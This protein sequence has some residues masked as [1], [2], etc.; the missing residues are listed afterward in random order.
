VTKQTNRSRRNEKGEGNWAS[1][2][3]PTE[4]KKCGGGEIKVNGWVAAPLRGG[5]DRKTIRAQ[6]GKDTGS[7]RKPEP[8]YVK[9]KKR[10]NLYQPGTPRKVW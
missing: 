2:Q 3:P 8:G 5:R 1:K 7:Q 4:G 10:L 6:N 9:K